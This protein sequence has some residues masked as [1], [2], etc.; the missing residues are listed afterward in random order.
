M[1]SLAFLF[2]DDAYLAADPPAPSA[3][4]V[5]DGVATARTACYGPVG[6]NRHA[7]FFLSCS[8]KL[9]VNL[10]WPTLVLADGIS[11]SN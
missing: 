11:G 4:T 2:S 9:A 1:H 10:F 6:Q 5:G 7:F 3:I 8:R